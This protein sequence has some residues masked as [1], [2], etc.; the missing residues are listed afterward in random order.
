M[1]F[2]CNLCFQAVLKA[3]MK[4]SK[5]NSNKISIHIVPRTINMMCLTKMLILTKIS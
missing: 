2:R 3:T 5:S 1:P 4:V